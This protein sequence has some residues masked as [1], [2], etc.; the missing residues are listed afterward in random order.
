M[1]LNFFPVRLRSALRRGY[2]PVRPKT[3]LEELAYRRVARRGFLP[4]SIV[5]VG[6][7]EGNWTRLARRVCPG[8]PVVMV[9]PQQ[10]KLRHL[11]S[12]TSALPATSFVQM[13]L[14][15]RAG[16][17]KIFFEMETGSSIFSENSNVQRRPKTLISHTLDEI[18]TALPEPIM[19]K[20]DVQGAELEVLKG[21][22]ATLKRC[23]LVQLEVAVACYNAG[24]P[25]MLE[26]LQFMEERGFRPFDI[27]GETRPNGADL[28]QIDL[29]FAPAGSSLHRSFFEF[30][31]RGETG[32]Q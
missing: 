7:Y 15:A 23:G 1:A 26:V 5:D 22:E 28:V 32:S 9:E 30:P 27:S 24:A 13:L 14:T 11:E 18:A 16:E 6:A 2:L 31:I 20:I 12:V 17:E 4:A 25:T 10:S 29:L 21:G 3:P 19:L 8:I